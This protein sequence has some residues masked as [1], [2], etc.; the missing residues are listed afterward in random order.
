LQISHITSRQLNYKQ[1]IYFLCFLVRQ[2]DRC[3]EITFLS[4]Q[5]FESGHNETL[6]I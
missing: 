4:H 5:N 1:L 3:P 6:N 2:N